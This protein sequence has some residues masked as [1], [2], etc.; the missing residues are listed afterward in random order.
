MV[1]GTERFASRGKQGVP[2]VNTPL[3]VL[4]CATRC[5][6]FYV[7]SI[8]VDWSLSSLQCYEMLGT[9]VLK[10]SSVTLYISSQKTM[11][12]TFLRSGALSVVAAHGFQLHCAYF[13]FIH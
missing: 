5:Y 8:Y 4:H 1:A 11:V 13:R 12:H 6:E 7:D 3:P 9:L 2:L 10:V